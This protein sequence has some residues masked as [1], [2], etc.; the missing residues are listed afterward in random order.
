VRIFDQQP[1]RLTAPSNAVRCDRISVCYAHRARSCLRRSLSAP[2]NVVRARSIRRHSEHDTGQHRDH[3]TKSSTR[4]FKLNRSAAPAPP[5]QA[6]A[7]SYPLP[8]I[9]ADAEDDN[10]KLSVS[11]FR[12]SG[13]VVPARAT[14][15]T[16]SCAP[17]PP[18]SSASSRNSRRNQQHQAYRLREHQQCR[19]SLLPHSCSELIGS[20]FLSRRILLREPAV[21]RGHIGLPCAR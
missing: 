12:T 5:A 1:A 21:D 11:V 6:G 15:I 7:G 14:R 16:N 13:A 4:V 19:R 17:R 9:S 10:S 20:P 2:G 8:N 18:A 3:R